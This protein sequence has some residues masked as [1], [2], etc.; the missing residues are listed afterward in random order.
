MR[1]EERSWLPS[2]VILGPTRW[3]CGI[4]VIV[5][6]RHCERRQLPLCSHLCT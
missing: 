5:S 4:V 1:V 3:W 2:S 6:Y